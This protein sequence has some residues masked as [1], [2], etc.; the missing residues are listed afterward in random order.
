M[1]TAAFRWLLRNFSTMLLALILAIVVWISAVLTT[2]PSVEFVRAVRVELVGQKEDLLLMQSV[3]SQVKVTLRAPRSV[4]DSITTYNGAIRAWLDLSSLE[5]GTHVVGIQTQI[6]ESFGSVRQ[7]QVSP[8]TATVILEPLVSQ[9]LPVILELSGEP[10]LGYQRGTLRYN[11]S[12]VTIRGAQSLVTQVTEVRGMLD[13]AEA[14]ATITREINL[15]ALDTNG[16]PVSGVDILPGKVQITLPISLQGGYRNVVVKV[17]TINQVVSG[18]KLTNISVSPPNVVV[19]SSDPQLV[20]ALPGFVETAPLDLEGADDDLDIYLP[21]NLPEGISVVGDQSVLV[22]V[23]IAAVEGSLRLPLPV[24]VDGLKPGLSASIS[25]D[26]VDV[27]ISGPVPILN[28]LTAAQIHLVVNASGLEAGIYQLE[29]KV[30]A[31]PARLRVE[32]ILPIMVEV[33]I[34]PTPLPTN[35]PTPTSSPLATPTVQP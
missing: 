26:N 33:T 12:V 15:Q 5:A 6:D 24:T 9:S 13:I 11:P 18:Y 27:I 7:I 22:Q 17:V 16:E 28:E 30:E 19:F 29:V 20:Q 2:D 25:P 35:T 4:R 3:P 14:R 10:A 34:F 31:L 21:L 8:D 32:T 23:S 1:F